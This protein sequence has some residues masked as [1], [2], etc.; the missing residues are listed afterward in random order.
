MVSG[1]VSNQTE[2]AFKLFFEDLR[3]FTHHHGA[4]PSPPRSRVPVRVGHWEGVSRLA[5]MGYER[6]PLPVRLQLRQLKP[7]GRPVVGGAKDKAGPQ[8]FPLSP[9]TVGK[10][11]ELTGLEGIKSI[12]FR[13]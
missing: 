7:S 13:I 12:S 8:P 4:A 10:W 2:R 9:R 1:A 11:E 5:H 6:S 3:I